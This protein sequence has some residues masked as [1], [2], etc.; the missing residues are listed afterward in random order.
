MAQF[1]L[2]WVNTIST[3]P[4]VIN[5]RASYKAKS[6]PTWLTAG[7]T[8]TNDLD[9]TAITADTPNTLLD[10]VIYQTKVETIC[11][12]GGP[13]IND[14]GIREQVSFA[15]ISPGLTETSTTGTI[16]IDLTGTDITKARFTLRK[17]SDN[18]IV[19]AP[20]IVSK[21]GSSVT[22][23]KTGLT[24]ST[25]YYWQVEFYT[26]INSIE[27]ISSDGAYTGAVFSPYA[28]TTDAPP[29]CN[30]VTAGTIS[31]IEIP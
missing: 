31:S 8:P 27:V 19:L 9:K 15:A 29:V 7:F 20:T 23:T 18:S 13:T 12:S 21:S 17:A 30:P 16:T 25:N 11:T 1:T 3:N 6:S 26:T 10:N 4:N 22:Y 24:G 28:F 14:N 5:L 2:N